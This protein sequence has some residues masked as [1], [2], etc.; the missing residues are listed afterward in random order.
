[1]AEATVHEASDADVDSAYAVLEACNGGPWFDVG[2]EEF[3]S[4]WPTYRGRWIAEEDGTVGYAAALGEQVEVYVLPEARRRGTGSQLLARAES[5]LEGAPATATARRDEK[6]AAPFLVAHGYAPVAETWLMQ[7]ELRDVTAEPRWPDGYEVR[8]FDLADAEAVK[9]LLDAAYANEPGFRERPFEEWRRLMIEFSAFA[10]E[11][12]FVV[13]ARD[14]SLAAAALN[15]E[16]GFLKDLVVHPDQQGRG[17]GKALL[18]HTLAHFR[19][20]G[21]PRLTLKT[22]SSNTSQAWRF[23]EHMG[24]RK[25][26]TYDDY[27]KELVRG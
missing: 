20:L 24:L 6:A 12:W 18:L 7:V 9:N 11:N 1:V 21:E 13:E 22:D 10:P 8:T 14:G 4:W 5:V 15:W 26:Q 19:A 27:L 23:Y 3:R 16:G 17:L 2:I 25:A